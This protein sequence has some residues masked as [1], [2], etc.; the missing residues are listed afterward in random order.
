MNLD[1]DDVRLRITPATRAVMPVH[2]GGNPCELDSIHDIARRHKLRVIEDAAHALPSRYR[3]RKIGSISEITCFSFYATKTLT[4]GEGGMVTTANDAAAERIRLMR[5]HGIAGRDRTEQLNGHAWSYA[6]CEAGF[7][8]N[9]TD[10]QA[11]MGIVQL[12]KCDAMREARRRIAERYSDAFQGIDALEIP[13]VPKDRE[14]SWHLYVLRLD[15]ERL[16]ADRNAFITRMSELGVACSV[17]FIP[18]H[19]HEHYR[20]AYGYR[21]GDFP[22]A[23]SEFRRCV[24]LPIYPDLSDEEIEYVIAAV[25]HVIDELHVP[26]TI[27]A[28]A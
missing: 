26:R 25:K 21:A 19:L 5:L 7:K 22:R 2:L 20:R 24:S 8:Y 15:L 13:T 6:V 16:S 17:H 1:P 11:A 28:R 4:T 9:F 14:T 23:E 3:G 12:G 27:A 18:L 10:I